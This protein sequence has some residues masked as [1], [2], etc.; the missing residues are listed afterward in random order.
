MS[1]PHFYIGKTLEDG[2]CFYSSIYRFL[3][4]HKKLDDTY[5]KNNFR[6][7]N[8]D[9]GQQYNAIYDIKKESNKKAIIKINNINYDIFELPTND[10]KKEDEFIKKLREFLVKYIDKDPYSTVENMYNY[11]KKMDIQDFNTMLN[12]YGP[13]MKNALLNYDFTRNKLEGFKNTLKTVVIVINNWVSQ[14]DFKI[15]KEIF[16]KLFFFKIKVIT[17]TLDIDIKY[18]TKFDFDDNTIYLI[19]FKGNHYQFILTDKN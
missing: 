3:L 19:N 16:E 12:D 14:N 17:E 10:I 1:N 11:Y 8:L 4:Y 6:F 13:Q 9:K 7:L 5:I 18:N 2:S 15:I